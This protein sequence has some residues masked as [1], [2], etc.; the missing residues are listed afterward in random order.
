[1]TS[2]IPN[3]TQ[4][5]TRP[6]LHAIVNH[7]SL[8]MKSVSELMFREHGLHHLKVM[9]LSGIPVLDH[10]NRPSPPV[11]NENPT[12]FTQLIKIRLL[13]T[14]SKYVVPES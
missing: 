12:A 10:D 1:M 14:A 4:Y 9:K 11:F 8:G 5:Q 13:D 6:I 7:V 2:V 3:T